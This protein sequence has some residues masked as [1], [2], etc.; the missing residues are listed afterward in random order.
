MVSFFYGTSYVNPLLVVVTRV[1]LIFDPTLFCSAR[2]ITEFIS[3][4]RGKYLSC[5]ISLSVH[6]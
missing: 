4:I 2:T 1:L 3:P 6:M 5:L